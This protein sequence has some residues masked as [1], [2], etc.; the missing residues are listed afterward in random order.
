MRKL[1][2]VI[3]V[4]CLLAGNASMAPAQVGIS[5]S[6]SP[7]MA[8]P[9]SS[10]G[11]YGG[12][13]YGRSTYGGTGGYGGYGY[14]APVNMD[15]R[16]GSM[17]VPGP[18]PGTFHYFNQPGVGYF[19]SNPYA[20]ACPAYPAPVPMAGGYFR[21]GTLGASC[22]YWR[23]PSG[24]YYPWCPQIYTGGVVY[25]GPAP[26]FTVQQG[27]A[28]QARPVLSAVFSDMRQ[29][30]EDSRSKDKLSVNDY[31]H[32]MQRLN[33]L[34]SKQSQLSAAGGGIMDPSDEEAIRR[35]LD[36]LSGEISRAL[37]P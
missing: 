14:G 37:Q 18:G 15:P 24:Y 30:L 11:G 2:I 28:T 31:T 8:Q 32:L 3:G 23:S 16:P 4:S 12:Y 21:F 25:S 5:S 36:L 9:G 29:F 22:G 26:V 33:D 35:D 34:M 7:V 20:P 27:V 19:Y 10:Y 13:G 17:M 1:A 6:S